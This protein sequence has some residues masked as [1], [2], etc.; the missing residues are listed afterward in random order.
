MQ[1]DLGWTRAQTSG[2]IACSYLT[3]GLFA[4][5]VGRLVDRHG[6]RLLMVGGSV[7]GATTMLAMAHIQTIWQAY[8]V[9]GVGT[10]L[11]LGLTTNE[12]PFTA[13]ANWFHKKRGAALAL[14][15]ALGGLGVPLFLPIAGSMV[16]NNG[17][18]L[19]V[20]AAAVLFAFTLPLNLLFLRRRPEDLDLL[21]D[22][23]QQSLSFGNYVP[24]GMRLAEAV[25]Q[26]A[27]WTLA[28]SATL[29]YVSSGVVAVHQIAYLIGRGYDPVFAAS[30]VAGIGLISIPGRAIFNL[31]S[32]RF[33]AQAL[34]AFSSGAQACGIAI[35]LLATS[36][37]ALFV[38]AAVYG[39]TLGAIGPLRATVIAAHFGRK[40][41]GAI[42]TSIGAPSYWGAAVGSLAAGWM[43]DIFGNY[44]LAILLSSALAA[45]AAG[46]VVITPRA[47]HRWSSPPVAPLDQL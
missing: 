30:L 32:D 15:A 14:M 45:I 5:M 25:H 34:L 47:P 27:F 1:R 38:Y 31:A 11:A 41:Y 8:F 35:L 20:E 7:I 4:A 18:R 10:G 40:A 26:L 24:Q 6:P 19:T 44:R 3:W 9:W 37:T 13:I 22:G 17:W 28:T 2:L 29:A 39:L 12:V 16:E 23:G 43:F 46:L 36:T 21:P 42:A 33:G